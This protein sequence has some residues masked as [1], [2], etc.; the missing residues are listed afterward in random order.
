MKNQWIKISYIN[1]SIILHDYWLKKIGKYGF[2]KNLTN[3]SH[4][5]YNLPKCL[6]KF[7]SCLSIHH[8]TTGHAIN[9]GQGSNLQCPIIPWPVIVTLTPPLLLNLFWLHLL[10]FCSIPVSQ[11]WILQNSCL[12]LNRHSK[13]LPNSEIFQTQQFQ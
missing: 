2:K 13:W 9:V 8:T 3:T 11:V 4:L 5:A 10:P 12:S 7:L 6:W 1:Y